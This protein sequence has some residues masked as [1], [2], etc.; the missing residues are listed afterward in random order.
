MA[1]STRVQQL[2]YQSRKLPRTLY[3]PHTESLICPEHTNR[4]CTWTRISRRSVIAIV[5]H[6]SQQTLLGPLTV[7]GA[8][9]SCFG[10]RYRDVLYQN[11]DEN[12]NTQTSTDCLLYSSISYVNNSIIVRVCVCATYSLLGSPI[13][14]VVIYVESNSV[15]LLQMMIPLLLCRQQGK[16]PT[17]IYM[18][19]GTAGETSMPPLTCECFSSAALAPQ[20]STVPA[21][22]HGA[23]V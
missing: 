8:R 17:K 7:T 13:L 14:S 21:T 20:R 2:Q 23:C 19:C 5:W 4:E 18:E 1:N 22:V 6:F 3:F 16:E 10:E 15:R 12:N 9:A 11:L